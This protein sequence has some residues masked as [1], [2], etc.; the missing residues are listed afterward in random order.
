MLHICLNAGNNIIWQE[1]ES[2][3][4]SDAIAHDMLGGTSLSEAAKEPGL[5]FCTD[6][7]QPT[8]N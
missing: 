5:S 3:S 7:F 1:A 8:E 2:R 6:L 4:A